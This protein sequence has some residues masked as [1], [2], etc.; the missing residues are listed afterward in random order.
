MKVP[1]LP[2]CFSALTVAVY[3]PEWATLSRSDFLNVLSVRQWEEDC[4]QFFFSL[5]VVSAESQN[6]LRMTTDLMT[7]GWALVLPVLGSRSMR[8][9][10]L[11]DGREPW[12]LQRL[13]R[14]LVETCKVCL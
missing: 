6:L 10:L 7:E 9:P 4:R 11:P 14:I 1:G 5:S 13:W 8:N 2:R 12:S 3:L